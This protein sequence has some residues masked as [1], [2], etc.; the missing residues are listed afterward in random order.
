MPLHGKETEAG[1]WGG[2]DGFDDCVL[3]APRGDAEAVTGSGDGLVMRGVDREAGISVVQGGLAKGEERG[4]GGVG[5][6][7]RG[8]GDG[9][10]WAG[11]VVDGEDAEVLVEGAAAPGVDGLKAEADAED[12]FAESL[13]VFE[14]EEV[15]GFAG[16]IGR[17]GGGVGL[18]PVA[19][20]IDV[21]G[22]AGEEDGGAGLSEGL[23]LRGGGGEGDLDGEAAE[24]ARLR[25]DR[26]G[27]CGGCSR[28]RCGW[29]W[30]WRCGGSWLR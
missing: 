4:K 13:R 7:G 2:L 18:L 6:D 22:R 30:G 25:R 16:G 23:L 21:G 1:G 8:V 5:G 19:A 26:R 27:G 20:G 28:S 15:G 29:G 24:P 14:K 10:G 3:R 17:G 12:R 9:D 11:R